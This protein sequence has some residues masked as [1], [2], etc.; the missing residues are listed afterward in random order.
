MSRGGSQEAYI[1][2][3]FSDPVDAFVHTYAAMRARMQNE[4]LN[5]KYLASL[6][7][8]L[9]SLCRLT[10]QFFVVGGQVD[11]IGSVG[12]DIPQAARL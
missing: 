2:E 12:H 11:K 7:L 1:S 9:Q 6:H 5:T 4:V 3:T 8:I 10:Q